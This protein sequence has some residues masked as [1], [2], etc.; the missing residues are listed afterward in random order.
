[1]FILHRP[2]IAVPRSALH[3]GLHED[4]ISVYASRTLFRVVSLT[5]GKCGDPVA[6]LIRVQVGAIKV[7]ARF[8]RKHRED[9]TRSTPRMAVTI[10]KQGPFCLPFAFYKQKSGRM[11][12]RGSKKGTTTS[13][14]PHVHSELRQAQQIMAKTV[15]ESIKHPPRT[16]PAT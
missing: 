4:R 12:S 16:R 7:S 15:A 8:F 9:R 1:M 10:D 5:Q 14:N 3:D 13:D 11:N 2:P 6:A